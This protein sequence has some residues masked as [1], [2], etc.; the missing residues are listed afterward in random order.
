M[1]VLRAVAPGLTGSARARF[2]TAA[3]LRCTPTVL[4]QASRPADRHLQAVASTAPIPASPAQRHGDDAASGCSGR[5]SSPPRPATAA[6]SG[7]HASSQ[8]HGDGS[9]PPIQLAANMIEHVQFPALASPSAPSHSIRRAVAVHNSDTWHIFWGWARKELNEVGGIIRLRPCMQRGPRSHAQALRYALPLVFD[10]PSVEGFA[11]CRNSPRL[12][13]QRASL[14]R[15]EIAALS[16]V[17]SRAQLATPHSAFPVEAM[18][19]CSFTRELV[20]IFLLTKRDHGFSMTNLSPEDPR[21]GETM[22]RFGPD[23]SKI[24]KL[25]HFSLYILGRQ[26]QGLEALPDSIAQL[27]LRASTVCARV[28]DFLASSGYAPSTEAGFVASLKRCISL[29]YKFQLAQIDSLEAESGPT[30]AHPNSPVAVA[31]ARYPALLAIVTRLGDHV[32]QL[33][34]LT[35]RAQAAKRSEAFHRA[36]GDYISDT[37]RLATLQ[38]LSRALLACTSVW[39]ALVDLAVRSRSG[40]SRHRHGT[41]TAAF[42]QLPYAFHC[43]SADVLIAAICSRGFGQ[44]GSSIKLPRIGDVSFRTAGINGERQQVAEIVFIAEKATF[45]FSGARPLAFNGVVARA[46]QAWSRVRH[47]QCSIQHSSA[48]AID[49]QPFFTRPATH[50]EDANSFGVGLSD[51]YVRTALKSVYWDMARLPISPRPLRTSFAQ[52]LYPDAYQQGEAAVTALL[53]VMNHH[54]VRWL[55]GRAALRQARRA[56]VR[57]PCSCHAVSGDRAPALSPT[58]CEAEWGRGVKC[59]DAPGRGPRSPSRHGRRRALHHHAPP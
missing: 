41:R 57:S 9:S 32:R 16:A 22:E 17:P 56:T 6:F 33:N 38:M 50:R 4:P 48:S 29:S 24:R 7:V 37:T 47:A 5:S 45:L 39:T 25:V 51:E 30:G 55:A 8:S 40:S 10:A 11:Y 54:E 27:S 31:R 46:L 19:H 15:T 2:P 14:S 44:R 59:L 34:N 42:L 3:V 23:V 52:E 35:R 28:S 43:L 36:N 58:L 18:L 13:E 26:D 53:G 49:Q 1:T 21:Y 20:E 12:P